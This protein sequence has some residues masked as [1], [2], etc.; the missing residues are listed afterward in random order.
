[1]IKLFNK[2]KEIINYL[3]F[4]VLTTIVSLVVYYGLVA[5]ILDASNPFELQIA[6]IIS[7][8][9]S[10]LFAYITNRKYVFASTNKNKLKEVS[11]FF[12]SRI[13]TLIIDMAIMYL[14]VSLLKGSD[15]II[16]LISQVIVIV[17]NYILSKLI[18]F[19]KEKE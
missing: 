11:T 4:G 6:N 19:K 9:I 18:V 15:T 8:I 17:G 14:G 16:K 13:V 10:V 12:S 5:T 2:Y 3:I 7:W 1:M